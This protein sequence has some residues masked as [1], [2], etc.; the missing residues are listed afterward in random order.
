MPNFYLFIATLVFFTF[1][2]PEKISFVLR[3]ILQWV[4]RQQAKQEAV[5]TRQNVVNE[6]MLD[7]V[8]WVATTQKQLRNRPTSGN[9]E[10]WLRQL[11]A[12]GE[13]Y[14]QTVNHDEQ[15][16]LYHFTETMV[17]DIAKEIEAGAGRHDD[18]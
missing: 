16:S 7:L 5:S 18:R 3:T 10:Q 11:R 12:A 15:P 14:L 17:R 9:K 2:F 8:T 1:L 13:R 4:Q 6:A